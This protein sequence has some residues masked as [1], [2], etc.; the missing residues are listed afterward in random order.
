MIDAVTIEGFRGLQR[1]EVEGFGRV[2][3]V[4]GK[5]DCGKTALM[6]ALM[7]AADAE[8][9]AHRALVLQAFRRSRDVGKEPVRDFDRYWRPLFWSLDAERGFSIAP[10]GAGR[11]SYRIVFRKSASPPTILTGESAGATVAPAP[12]AMDVEIAD[13]RVRAEQIVESAGGL[14]LPPLS[15]NRHPYWISPLDQLGWGEIG[16][17]SKLKQAG[18]EEQL[19]DILRLVDDRISGIEILALGGTEAEI[20]VRIG[21]GPPLLPLSAMG[22]GFKRCFQI[23]V[24]AAA[25]NGPVLFIDE[26][27]NG[28]HHS[29]LEPVWRWLATISKRRDLQVFAST[30]SEECIFAAGRAF[31]ALEDD[32]LRVI[33]LDRREDRTT[34]A[35]Y[36]RDL[37]EATERMGVEIRG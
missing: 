21:R 31:T 8:G 24:S 37:V 34:A 27:D 29:V 22:D 26:F 23:G 12:W 15:A 30:H 2:N 28:L 6:E 1:L 35:I 10:R 3:L 9:A 14:K 13:G 11:P 19:I 16:L 17:F 18:R 33:R 32:G 20:F 7:I 36:E 4:I 5:N 25:D